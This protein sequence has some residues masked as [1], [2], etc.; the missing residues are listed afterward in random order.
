M[1]VIG[2]E[3]S[4]LKLSFMWFRYSRFLKKNVKGLFTISEA[5]LILNF[6]EM[7]KWR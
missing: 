7:R 2:Y 5:I 1:I 6:S 3:T 4:N